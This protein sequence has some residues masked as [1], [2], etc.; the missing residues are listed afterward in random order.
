[1][2]PLDR[3]RR[4]AAADD[5]RL[6]LPSYDELA[7][8][9]RQRREAAPW[10][11]VAAAAAVVAIVVVSAL[12]VRQ[13]RAGVPAEVTAPTAPASA[14]PSARATPALA[15]N[16]AAFRGQ[17]R[18][19]F[20]TGQIMQVLD[21]VS[22]ESRL[23]GGAGLAAWSASGDWLAYQQ[24]VGPTAGSPSLEEL[25]LVRADGATKAKV[26]GLP[27]L[28]NLVFE[29]SP[30]DD[31]LAVMPQ[32]GADAKGLWLVRPGGSATLL[33]AGDAPV[34][35]FAWSFDGRTLAYSRTL[36]FTDPIGRSDALLT[37]EVSGGPPIQ[38]FVADGAGIVGIAWAPDGR[39][40]LYYDDPQHSGSLLADGVPLRTFALSPSARS[41]AFPDRKIDI[42]DE[43]IDPHRFIAVIGGNRFPTENKTLAI[44][45][46]ETLACAPLASE[47]GTVSLQ[48]ALS[49]DHGRVA[50][51]RAAESPGGGFTSEAA[52]AAWMRTRTLSIVDLRTGITQQQPAAG[53]GISVPAWSRDGQRLLLTRDQAAWLYDLGTRSSTKLIGPLDAATPFGGP[54]WS[55]AWQR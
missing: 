33:A 15:V 38:R 26:G 24:A 32:G 14:S 25:W 9:P 37:V 22:G 41:G 40:L 44:C 1:M 52:A 5:E 39:T 47:P 31:V 2:T 28:V 49:P 17:G 55:F 30:T 13:L 19:A 4:Y 7:R 10:L 23:V 50:F 8:R 48:P 46:I 16:V 42:F 51:V 43:W 54:G 34:W 20:S 11:A 21:G 35:S 36:P 53:T 45:D 27:P 18:L 6:D 12:G 29:W 3:L